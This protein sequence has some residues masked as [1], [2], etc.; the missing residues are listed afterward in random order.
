LLAFQGATW[1]AAKKN[2]GLINLHLKRDGNM[3]EKTSKNE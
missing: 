3:G 1:G 2:E